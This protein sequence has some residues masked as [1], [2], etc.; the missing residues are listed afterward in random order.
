MQK[1]FSVSKSFVRTL[2]INVED[3]LYGYRNL[4]ILFL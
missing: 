4:Q 2:Y 1:F 3:L